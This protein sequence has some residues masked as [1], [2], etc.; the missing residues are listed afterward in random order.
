MT[1]YFLVFFG[2][3]IVAVLLY[4]LYQ[5]LGGQPRRKDNRL[6]LE[7]L[8][9]LLDGKQE[10]AFGKLRRVVTE[11]SSNLDAYLRLGR[12][13]RENG[14][15]S[16][17]LQVHK[18]MTLRTDLTTQGRVD[19]LR[20]IALDYLDLDDTKMAEAALDELVNLE[21][22]NHWGHTRLLKIKEAAGDWA[23]AFDTAARI[24]QLEANK[25]KKPLARYKYKAGRQLYRQREY[26]K[27][28]VVLKEALG[29]DQTLVE[30]Y[31]LIGDSYREEERLEDAVT[32][33]QKL[34][35][36]V[37]DQGHR[38]IERLKRTLFDLGRFGD[39]QGICEAILEHSPRNLEAR[40]A[41]AEFYEKK[42]DLDSTLEL[43]EQL[44]E[45]HPNDTRCTL[46]LIRVYLEKHDLAAI[47]KLIK[48]KENLQTNTSTSRGGSGKIDDFDQAGVNA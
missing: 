48:D 38:V 34:I 35:T 18:D 5:R 28:R 41:L 44:A 42:G 11:D 3:L 6:Y 2:L 32:F 24:L 37:P 13:L 10:T 21:P 31:L 14:Q 7:S 47:R 39:I 23:A 25:S 16:R 33:W 22:N 27:A 9:D 15:P 43:W 26:H 46:E 40:Q 1:E 19:I 36:S 12:I 8:R 30:A 20:E 4:L 29:L 45:E 17:A